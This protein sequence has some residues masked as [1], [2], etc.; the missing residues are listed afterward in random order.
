MFFL[1]ML[2]EQ[3]IIIILFCI[4]NIVNVYYCMGSSVK[5]LP[6]GASKV[7]LVS[8]VLVGPTRGKPVL[9]H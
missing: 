1:V 3:Q 6:G 5:V 7:C 8:T 2:L 9:D 4:K